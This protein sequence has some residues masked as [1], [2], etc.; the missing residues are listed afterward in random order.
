MHADYK[1]K[2]KEDIQNINQVLAVHKLRMTS[3]EEI[4]NLKV[5]RNTCNKVYTMSNETKEDQIFQ[6]VFN[7]I[8]RADK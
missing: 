3:T 5:L 4:Q 1:W 7:N 6:V 2:Y 8:K